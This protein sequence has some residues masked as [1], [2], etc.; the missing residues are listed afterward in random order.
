MVQGMKNI[1]SVIKNFETFDYLRGT[2]GAKN[3]FYE[4]IKP[5]LV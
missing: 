4:I 5:H 2:K 3:V 1:G